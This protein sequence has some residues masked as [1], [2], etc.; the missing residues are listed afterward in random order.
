MN[1]LTM[2]AKA[3]INL[4]LKVLN[5]R[6]DGYHNIESIMQLVNFGDKVTVTHTKESGISIDS[7]DRTLPSDE[8]NIAY[9]A[10]ALMQKTFDIEGGFHIRLDKKIPV[11]GGLAGGSTNAAAVMHL[12]NNLCKLNCTTKQLAQLGVT[13]GADVPFCI[14]GSPALTEGI[15]EKITPVKGLSDCHILLVNPG[16]GVSTAEIYKALDEENSP[17]DGDVRKL[18]R[19]LEAGDINSA[20]GEMKNVME[21]AAVCQC[22]QISELLTKLRDAGAVHSMMSGSGATCFGIFV[23]KPDEKEMRAVFG[24]DF[25]ALTTPSESVFS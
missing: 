21:S 7:S 5:K 24:E 10:A 6:Q 4:F 8:G 22:H 13:L 15:G 23:E 2:T 17:V 1:S 20:F 12:V 11:A 9:R 3:K 19:Y 18:A 16:V 14:Y 25:V